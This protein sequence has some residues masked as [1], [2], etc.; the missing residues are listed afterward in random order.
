MNYIEAFLDIIFPKVCGFCGSICTNALCKKCEI[1]LKN[2]QNGGYNTNPIKQGI[3]YFDK[4][5]YLAKYEGI[6][7][8]KLIEYKFKDKSY[9]AQTFAQMIIKD[10]KICRFF[11]KYDII[12]SVP[13]HKERKKQ[14]GYDQCELII[15]NLDKMNMNIKVEKDILV[16]TKNIKPQSTLN[17]K[18]RM[19]NIKNVYSIKNSEKVKGKSIIIFD[20]IYTTGSTVNECS[21]ML[22]LVG[23]DKIGIL[24]IAKD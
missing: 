12:T 22:K 9:L 10:E 17:K 2:K 11:K 14:R 21:R 15:K 6:I 5:I 18:N 24:T 7:K 13:V 20:D 16:K 3:Q 4:H 1:T 23:T 19:K 8:K